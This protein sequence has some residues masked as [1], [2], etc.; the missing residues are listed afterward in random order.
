MARKPVDSGLTSEDH[1]LWRQVVREAAPLKKPAEPVS[2]R[3]PPEPP[4]AEKTTKA[5]NRPAP[6]NAPRSTPAPPRLPP[7]PSPPSPAP[8]SLGAAPGLDR[9]SAERL[10][11]GK[12][13]IEAT[14][15]LHGFTQDQARR[16]LDA[17]L[18]RA[19]AGER[20]CVL[21]IT[22]KGTTKT[23]GGVLRTQ[24]PRWL[25][26]RPNRERILAF[27]RAQDRHGG[28]GALYILLRRKRRG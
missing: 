9:R 8:L 28:L 11:R 6:P 18:A 4:R 19:Q 5:R 3:A 12:L 13:P 23:Q 26:L 15:D 20:R 22:G 21:V 24:V 25:N 27:A 1:D 16:E 10:R 2:P 14:L 7:S 17:F